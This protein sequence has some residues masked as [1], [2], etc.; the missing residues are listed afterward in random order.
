MELKEKLC[1]F[2]AARPLLSVL[3]LAI[4]IMSTMDL[5]YATLPWESEVHKKIKCK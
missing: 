1:S 4:V 2:S 5:Q 3:K